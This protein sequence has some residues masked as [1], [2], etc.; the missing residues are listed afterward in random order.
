MGGHAIMVVQ[1]IDIGTLQP[2]PSCN[3]KTS[4]LEVYIQLNSLFHMYVYIELLP[5]MLADAKTQKSFFYM[6][7][8]TCDYCNKLKLLTDAETQQTLFYY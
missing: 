4:L 7:I 5:K 3:T 1:G 6:F 2:V 8:S